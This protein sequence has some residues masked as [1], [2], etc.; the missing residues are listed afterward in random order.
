MVKIG[1]VRIRGLKGK[2]P[3]VTQTFELLHLDR[4]N[5]CAVYEDSPSLR[6]MLHAVKDFGT[7]GEIDQ[8]T[9]ELLIEKRGVVGKSKFAKV[10]AA[11]K[12]DAKAAAAEIFTGKKKYEDYGLKPYF[13]LTPPSGGHGTIKR[14]YPEGALGK[15]DKEAFVS[16]VKSMC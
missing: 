15:R 6:G 7:W 2:P 11:K 1:I 9:F 13:R 4:V 16:L 5:R 10:A 12:I 14:T 3:K 8:K